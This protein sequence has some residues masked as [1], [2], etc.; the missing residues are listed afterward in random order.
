MATATAVLI[1]GFSRRTTPPEVPFVKVTRETVISALNTNGKV[2]PIEWASARAERQGVVEKIFVQRGQNV[3]AG[4]PLV[5]LDTSTALSQLAAANAQIAQAKE[6]ELVITQGGPQ[7][8]RTQIE[9]EL[10]AARLS[11]RNEQREFEALQRLVAKQAATRV[12]LEVARQRVEATNLEIQGLEKRR[13]ALVTSADLP[14]ARAK[15]NEAQAAAEAAQRLLSQSVVRAPISGVLYQFDLRIGSFLDPGD[16]VGNV[17]QLDKVRVVV[18]VDEPDLG[19]VEKRM[20]VTITWDALPGR[21]WKG[22]VDKLPTQIVP[23]GSRQVGEVSCIINNPDHDLLPGT[24][25][26]AEIQSRV[27]TNALTIPKEAIRREG[28]T[29]GVFV[30][31]GEKAVWKPLKLGV[32]SYTKTQVAQGLADGDSI[33]LPTDK[34]IKSGQRVRPKF[35]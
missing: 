34:A 13:A 17:G 9:N 28:D 7:A 8:Q 31:S 16:L 27:V 32:A 20:P 1:W 5:E 2:E 18:Y 25:I 11:L 35:Q 4:D 21:Q 14:V 29:N 30:L 15:L 12:D 24:N 3:A 6:Q 23:L 10:S 22:E 26:N 19:R 33:M